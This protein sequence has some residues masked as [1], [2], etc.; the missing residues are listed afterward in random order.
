MPIL[1]LTRNQFASFL[2]DAEQIKQFEQLFRVAN[3]SVTVDTST[4]DDG[5]YIYWDAAQQAWVTAQPDELSRVNDANVTLTLGGVPTMALFNPVSLTLGW[6]GELAVSRGGTGGSVPSGTL[7]DNI[8]GFSGTGLLTRT[9][10]GLYAFR[11]NTGTANRITVTN[12]DGIAGNPT[13][14]IAATYVGQTSITTLGT[15]T[16]GV[17]NGTTITAGFGGTGISTYT[18]GDLIYATGATTL[19]KLAIGANNFMLGSNGTAPVWVTNTGT[20]NAVRATLPQI[21]STIGVGAPASASGS[22]VTFPATQAPSTDPNTLDDYEEAA[23]TPTITSGTGTITTLGAV[24]GSYTK[25][26]RKVTVTV[27]IIITT[28]GTAATRIDATLPFTSKATDVFIG[29]GREN[30]VTGHMLSGLILPSTATMQIF[31]YDGTYPGG[32]GTRLDVTATYF[33]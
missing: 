5:D 23:Y 16:T 30:A 28:N 11:T 31:K 13:F 1:K 17:W 3:G 12:G 7:L 20:G 10:A 14:D 25:I 32:S 2:K 19:V 15:I 21:T 27:G 24:T 18:A 29:A 9:G 26:G 8:T 33:V 6:Q 22:G 4:L